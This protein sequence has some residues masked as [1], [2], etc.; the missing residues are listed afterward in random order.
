MDFVTI[1]WRSS[2]NGFGSVATMA[3][4]NLTIG[5]A[6]YTKGDIFGKGL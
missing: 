6:M 2:F 4:A 5:D 3:E 1:Y